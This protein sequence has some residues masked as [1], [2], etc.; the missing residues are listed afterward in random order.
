MEHWPTKTTKTLPKYPDGLHVLLAVEN[1]RPGTG[2]S[3]LHGLQHERHLQ[4]LA[5][6]PVHDVAAIPVDDSHEIHP[7]AFEADI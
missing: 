2:Q 7:S 1:H 4:A 3:L 6:A 5:E